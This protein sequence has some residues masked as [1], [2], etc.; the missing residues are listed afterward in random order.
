VDDLKSKND[1]DLRGRLDEVNKKMADVLS[2]AKS[3]DTYDMSKV[4]SIDGDS[5]AKVD[6]IRAWKA[7]QDAIGA[8]LDERKELSGY[9]SNLAARKEPARLPLPGSNGKKAQQETELQSIGELF[10]ESAAYKGWSPG[11]SEGPTANLGGVNLMATLFQTSG[12]W[13][14]PA[15]RG[16]RVV[17]FAVRQLR[18]ADLLPQSTTT[19]AS[20]IYME[21]TTFTNAAVEVTEGSAKPEA[22][23]AL[24]ERTEPVRKIAVYLP[25]TDEQLA[26]VPQVRAYIDNRLGYMV[27]A[28]LDGQ[29]LNGNGTAPNLAGITDDS[30]TGLQTQAKG[31]DPTPDAVYKAMTKIRVNAFSEPN[32]VVF[33]PNDWQDIR[34]LRT[35]DGI[36][37]WGNPADAGPERI[38]GL[39]VV[40]TTAETENT[41]LVGDFNQAELIMREGLNLKVGYVNDDLIKNR[42]TIVAE[43]RAAVA[44]YRPAA[45]CTVTGI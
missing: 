9:E 5:A 29:I 2:E 20:V 6:Q 4:S 26:D 14:P 16:P 33:H 8:E 17:D 42:Q 44:V 21:E 24:T 11:V 41:A 43:L 37:I 25:V 28:R 18:V 15:V 32:A 12:G 30:R 22:A 39:N 40:Q 1:V 7:E 31:S 34:L 13:S 45:F 38:W 10:I 36:Y 3:G 35:A 19:Q 27:R 23:L